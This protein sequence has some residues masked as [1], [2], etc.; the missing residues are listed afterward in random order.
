[1][2]EQSE[3]G[4]EIYAEADAYKMMSDALF[5]AGLHIQEAQIR[6]IPNQ[7]ID[8]PLDDTLQV[9]RVIDALEE[10]DDVQQVYHNMNIS[11]EAIAALENE[12]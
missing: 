9:L 7:P 4:I 11:D 8:L 3:D 6:M 2:V 5:A 12:E 10:L 1:D